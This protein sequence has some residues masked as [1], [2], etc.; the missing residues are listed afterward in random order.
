M[1]RRPKHVIFLGAGASV[2]SGYPLGVDLRKDWL[3]SERS[4][5]A[6]VE[7]QLTLPKEHPHYQTHLESLRTAFYQWYDSHKWSLALFRDGGFGSIDEFCYHLRDSNPDAVQNLKDVLRFALGIHNPEPNFAKSDYYSLIQKLF[8]PSDLARLTD[9][10]VIL[11]FNY[12]PYLEYL[13]LRALRVRDGSKGTRS[14]GNLL[15]QAARIGSGFL[16]GNTGLNE[17]SSSDGFCVLKLHGIIT[18]PDGGRGGRESMLP[19]CD[20]EDIMSGDISLRMQALTGE[21]SR[22]PAPIVFPWEI[23]APDGTFV[24]EA[25]FCLKEI[26]EMRFNG[27]AI[28]PGNRTQ[29]ADPSVYSIFKAIWERARSEVQAATSISFVGISMHPYLSDGLKYLFAGK[30]GGFKWTITDRESAK[31]NHEET[32]S[33]TNRAQRFFQS[34]GISPGVPPVFRSSFEEFI[35]RDLD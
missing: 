7:N 11:S 28:L 34:Y 2:T 33:P 17:I 23:L 18:W 13:L 10:I 5:F 21:A 9:D 20:I 14:K 8:L 32:P 3:S 12:D 31:S 27:V 29:G 1:S 35:Y 16:A 4:L 6:K 22:H 15:S 26:S 30:A 19:C 25:E 24:P